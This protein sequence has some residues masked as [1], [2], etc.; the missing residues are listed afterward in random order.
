[1]WEFPERKGFQGFNFIYFKGKG[2]VDGRGL[3]GI[4]MAAN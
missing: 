4:K 1:M 2:V 3:G